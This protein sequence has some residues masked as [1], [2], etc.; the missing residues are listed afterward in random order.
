MASV[1]FFVRTSSSCLLHMV[2]AN[3]LGFFSLRSFLGKLEP[4]LS[5]TMANL[6][7]KDQIGNSFGFAG[8]GSP[9]NLT[10]PCGRMKAATDI[11]K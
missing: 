10:L 4:S 8:Y 6:S 3:F 1:S 11:P 2:S 9:S 5:N 7:L